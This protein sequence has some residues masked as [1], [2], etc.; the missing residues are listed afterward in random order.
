MELI[1]D[2]D[3][4]VSDGASVL[5]FGGNAASEIFQEAI[6]ELLT[7]LPGCKN[8]SDDIIVF[9]KSQDEHDKNLRGVL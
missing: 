5:P 7:G 1:P 6:R 3:M 8:I 2:T 4:L 9:G